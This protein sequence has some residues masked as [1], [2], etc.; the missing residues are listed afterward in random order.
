MIAAFCVFGP[1]LWCFVVWLMSL[2]SGWQRM[3]RHF[4]AGARQPA[5]KAFRHVTARIGWVHY[6]HVLEVHVGQA[7][8]FLSLPWLF[9]IGHAPLLLPWSALRHLGRRRQ[10]FLEWD[11]FEVEKAGVRLMLPAGLI[12][13]RKE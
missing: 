12:E 13:R 10:L 7:G 5:G 8:V 11:R 9:R 6:K 1:A 4:A 2:V 3:A